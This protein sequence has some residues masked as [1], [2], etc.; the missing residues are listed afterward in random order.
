MKVAIETLDDKQ[1]FEMIN[2]ELLSE[3]LGKDIANVSIFGNN[4]NYVV[5]NNETQEDDELVYIDLGMNINIYELAH[6]CKEWLLGKVSNLNS[7]FDNG[8]RCFC[9]IENGSK[10]DRFYADT[11]A[12]AIFKACKWVLKEIKKEGQ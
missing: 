5:E 11:E 7:G 8:Q 3:V 12:E 10:E 2:K 9:H 1:G 6:K 4:I